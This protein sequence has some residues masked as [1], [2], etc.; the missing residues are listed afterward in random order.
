M[1]WKLKRRFF[2]EGE[3]E[4]QLSGLL[5][6]V[7]QFELQGVHRP[8]TAT[9]LLFFEQDP[10]QVPALWFRTRLFGQEVQKLVLSEHVKH[11]ESHVLHTFVF[12]SNT[13]MPSGHLSIHL[14]SINE[15]TY[16]PLQEVQVS[17]L[18]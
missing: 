11:F 7:S 4:R 1:H 3:Q 12:G 10:E 5:I 8:L 16:F 18:S 9:C 13:V 14:L 17:E 6:Q 15:S 2:E